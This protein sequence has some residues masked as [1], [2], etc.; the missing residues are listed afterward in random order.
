MKSAHL[1]GTRLATAC[2]IL[3]HTALAQTKVERAPLSTFDYDAKAPLDIRELT[4]TDRA[5][6]TLIDLTYA[7][8]GRRTR[9]GSEPKKVKWYH[10][11]HGLNRRAY[12]N[13][14]EW[15]G[16]ALTL[17]RQRGSLMQIMCQ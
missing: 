11:N 3:T 16:Q 9:A 6:Y 7:S 15:L 1:Y 12:R 14:A 13:Q 8:P 5:G 17:K 2:A 10:A 4:T